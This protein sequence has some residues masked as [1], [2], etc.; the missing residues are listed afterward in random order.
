MPHAGDWRSGD[1]VPHAH[2]LNDPLR[3]QWHSPTPHGTLPRRY[4]FARVDVDHVIV[5][6]VKQVEGERAWIVR[7]YEYKQARGNVNLLF[8]QP[9]QRI[10]E[11][12]LIEQDL[13]EI[14]PDENRIAFLIEPF[15]IKTF[16]VWFQS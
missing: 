4:E 1:V 6:T 7:L 16:K 3:A 12:N 13:K 15:E 11:C 10:I 2:A 9:I 14:E 8:A 5:E